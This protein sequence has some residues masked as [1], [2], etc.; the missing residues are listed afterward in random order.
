MS[1]P[2][3]MGTDGVRGPAGVWPLDEAGLRRIGR[4]VAEIARGPVVV[5][6][7]TRESSPALA[8]ALVR[9]LIAGGAPAWRAGVLPTPALSAAVAALGASAGA[10]ITASHNPWMDN[11]V[12]VVGPDGAKTPD[13]AALEAAL[14][15]D[16][17]DAPQ[18]AEVKDL[19]DPTAPWRAR[20]PKLDLRGLR[21]LLDCANGAASTVAPQVLADLGATLTLRGV[22]PDGRNINDGC[23]AL[24]PPRDLGDADLAICLD[25]DADRLTLVDPARGALDGDDLL[26]MLAA[27][28]PD[29]PVV[30]TL[31]SNGG[32]GAALGGRL[33]RVPVGDKHVHEGMVR[34][35]APLGGEP[36]GHT[37]FADGLPTACGLYTALRV[38]QGGW[39]LGPRLQGWT[40]WPAARRDVRRRVDVGALRSPR[41]AEEAGNRVLVRLSGTEALTRVLVEGPDPGPWADAIVTEILE[42]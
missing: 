32:L 19:V 20:L 28:A 39:P 15:A 16:L 33:I 27:E 13:E 17:S 24:H 21:V 29:R 34:A 18:A 42:S 22:S 1:A 26:W 35:G 25:G 6:W 37:L 31:M 36:S 10:M 5:G 7:D 3:R 41:Q 9:G 14:D 38:L 8:D 40:R 11:G 4:A 12:K 30:G 23:G 2:I